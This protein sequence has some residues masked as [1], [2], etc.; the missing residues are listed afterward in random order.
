MAGFIIEYQTKAGGLVVIDG[1]SVKYWIATGLPSFEGDLDG[2]EQ[3]YPDVIKEMLKR[4][5]LRKV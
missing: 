4:G 3:V 1:T 2:L 5:I